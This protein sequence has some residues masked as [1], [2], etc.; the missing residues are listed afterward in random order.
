MHGCMRDG[1]VV[2][3]VPSALLGLQEKRIGL[4]T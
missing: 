4:V 3:V 2:L 1:A